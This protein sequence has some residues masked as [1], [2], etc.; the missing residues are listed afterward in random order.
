MSTHWN[1]SGS[2][3]CRNPRPAEVEK[4]RLE[5]GLTIPEAAQLVCVGARAW[6]NWEAPRDSPSNRPMPPAAWELF[7]IKTGQ[8]PP[9]KPLNK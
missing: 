7:L 2:G 6:E 5:A 8:A 9:P 3:P 4:A 1:R